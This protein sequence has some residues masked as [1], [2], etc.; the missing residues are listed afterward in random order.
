[1]FKEQYFRNLKEEV[2]QNQL[3]NMLSIEFTE[4]NISY[5]IQPSHIKYNMLLLMG[6][7]Q[8]Q[9]LVSIQIKQKSRR[10]LISQLFVMHKLHWSTNFF[11]K[12]PS[13]WF[14]TDFHYFWVADSESKV[15]FGY[16]VIILQYCQFCGFRARKSNFRKFDKFFLK[17]SNIFLKTMK[18]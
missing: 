3:S 9:I 11:S 1:M 18:L 2:Q 16:L 17:I 15:F 13:I 4:I 7:I 6:L 10:G 14:L 5:Q 8:Q 12:M